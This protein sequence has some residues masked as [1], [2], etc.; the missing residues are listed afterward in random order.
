M[1]EISA[2]LTPEN[3]MVPGDTCLSREVNLPVEDCNPATP[4]M[5]ELTRI[6]QPQIMIRTRSMADSNILDAHAHFQSHSM[7]ILG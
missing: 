2:H 4:S 3:A 7:T 6:D 5:L 1:Y